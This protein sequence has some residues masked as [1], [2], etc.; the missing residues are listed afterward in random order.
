MPMANTFKLDHIHRLCQTL[1]VTIA[2]LRRANP[3]IGTCND[4]SFCS[5]L[6]EIRTSC[7]VG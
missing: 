1:F 7:L 2:N 5:D 4:Q 6:T 3:V